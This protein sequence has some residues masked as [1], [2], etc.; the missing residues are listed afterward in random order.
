[1]GGLT[2][3][4]T[5][6]FKLAATD[7]AGTS[8]TSTEVSATP[9][10]VPGKPTGLTASAG[11]DQVTLEVDRAGRQRRR[12]HRLR[13]LRRPHLRPRDQTAAR[14]RR[15]R[16]ARPA[17][18][19]RRPRDFN[20]FTYYI[21][22]AAVNAL[23]IGLASSEVTVTPSAVP[24][25]PTDLTAIPD[26]RSVLL[27]WS[28]PSSAGASPITG[29]DV[30][31]GTSSGGEDASPIASTTST[32]V[33]VRPDPGAR[34]RHDVLLHGAGRQRLGVSATCRAKCPRRR[35]RS[36]G[37]RQ[38]SARRRRTERSPSAGALRR[39]PAEARSPA[40]TCTR[41]PRWRVGDAGGEGHSASA[42]SVTV[43]GLTDGTTYFFT[44]RH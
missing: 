35:S 12:G 10:D 43:G 19:C 21:V 22:V 18:R 4:T 41:P 13:R 6:Y 24:E 39:R 14:R 42:T 28:A 25:S 44:S 37:A 9:A 5:Y 36:R 31:E 1:M 27:S 16:V 34:Q 15:R 2:D 11:N 20:G 17:S 26:N 23:G 3:G 29:Y 40:T 30:Y 32:S 33:M 7:Q 8:P 38:V